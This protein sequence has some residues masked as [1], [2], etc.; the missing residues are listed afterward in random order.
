V[1]SDLLEFPTRS[2]PVIVPAKLTT[3]MFEIIGAMAEF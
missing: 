2:I 3:V 1:R